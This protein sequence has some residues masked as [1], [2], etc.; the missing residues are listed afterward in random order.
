MKPNYLPNDTI[1]T[2]LGD[3]TAPYLKVTVW[4]QRLEYHQGPKSAPAQMKVSGVLRP[5]RL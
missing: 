2:S 1:Y 5:S 3:D 4:K